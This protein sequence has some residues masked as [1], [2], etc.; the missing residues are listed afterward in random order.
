MLVSSVAS[1]KCN[2]IAF[3]CIIPEENFAAS[4]SNKSKLIVFGLE[5]IKLKMEY[6]PINLKL[7]SQLI[8]FCWIMN[9][10]VRKFMLFNVFQ[11]VQ[12]PIKGFGGLQS[13]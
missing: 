5:I 1:S 2:R 6:F 12:G 10:V 7:Q 13:N 9:I 4:G 3:T 11:R 8:S